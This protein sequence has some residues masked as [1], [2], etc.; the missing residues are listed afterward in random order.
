[1]N[2]LLAILLFSGF[3]TLLG[4]LGGGTILILVLILWVVL[5]AGGEDDEIGDDE[6]EFN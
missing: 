4:W 5:P 2:L 3:G 6:G 1:M